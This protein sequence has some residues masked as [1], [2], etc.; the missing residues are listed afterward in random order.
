MFPVTLTRVT[1]VLVYADNSEEGTS[2]IFRVVGPP[3]TLKTEVVP[4]SET[5]VATNKSTLCQSP[6]DDHLF[7]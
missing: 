3:L 6:Q 5:L 2:Y 1:E 7:V 4:S